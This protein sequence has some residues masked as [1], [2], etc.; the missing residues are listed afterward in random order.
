L[1]NI[2]EYKPLDRTPRLISP[3]DG[4]DWRELDRWFQGIYRL[5]GGDGIEAG[6]YRYISELADDAVFTLPIIL[7]G[8]RGFVVVG[9][10][11]EHSDFT[12]KNDGTVTLAN[13]SANVVANANTDGKFCIGTSVA[14][15]CV[16]K[17]RLGAAKKILFHLWYG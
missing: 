10:N 3:Q 8:G 12:I 5:L 6:Q 17:N 7:T 1:S 4:Y 16:I 14:S 11:Q 13:N 15:P 9:E 2:G